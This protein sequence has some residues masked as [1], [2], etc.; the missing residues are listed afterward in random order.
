[1][2]NNIGRI[3][4]KRG[5]PVTSTFEF[6]PSEYRRNAQDCWAHAN[7][8][9]DEESKAVFQ[10]LAVAWENFAAVVENLQRYQSLSGRFVSPDP[11]LPA[12]LLVR[13]DFSS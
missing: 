3:V 10:V 2:L 12:S 9:M 11:Q 1:M 4:I 6:N 13:S 7:D 5:P 8:T